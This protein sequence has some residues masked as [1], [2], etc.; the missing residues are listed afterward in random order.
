MNSNTS[1][2]YKIKSMTY[3]D[4]DRFASEIRSEILKDVSLNGGHLASNLGVVELTL[5][6]HKVFDSPKDK[7][8][9]DVGHQAYVHKLLTGRW[10]EMETL[11]RHGGISGFPKR[12]ESPHDADDSGHSGSSISAAFG[13]AKARDLKGEDYGC[14][15]VIGDGSFTGGMPYEALNCAGSDGTPLI[16]I[17]NDNE[18]SI[19]ENSSSLSRYLERLRTSDAYQNL[20]SNIKNATRNMPSVNKS[21]GSIKKNIRSAIGESGELFESLGFKYYGPYDGHDIA[22]MCKAFRFARSARRPVVVHVITKKGKGFAPAEQN[23]EKYHG[24]GPFDISKA[25]ARPNPFGGTYSEYFGEILLK[26]AERDHSVCAVTAA[27]LDATGLKTLKRVHPERVFDEGIA[28]QHA[29]SFAAGLALNGMKPVVAI[30]ST[31][32]QRAYDQILT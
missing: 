5:A 16:V 22:E 9:W 21:L 1:L 26:L 11:R 28:E 7:I 15:A 14:V 20:K 18:M 27:M 3:A 19:S 30:Y 31:F 6:L 10:K 23:P 8:I 2:L 4:L 29:V 12:S 17:L 25:D 24:I 13:Y 32:L